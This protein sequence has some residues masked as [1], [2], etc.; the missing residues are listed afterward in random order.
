MN[1]TVLFTFLLPVK[2]TWMQKTK[3][4]HSTHERGEK[5]YEKINFL[6]TVIPYMSLCESFS[7]LHWTVELISFLESREYGQE[8]A[9]SPFL[10][11]EET[12]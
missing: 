9:V 1:Y 2:W 4:N 10:M 8:K 6:W 11:D 5:I 12:L 7:L 3:W